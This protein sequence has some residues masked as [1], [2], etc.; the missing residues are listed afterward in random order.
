MTNLLQHQ[1][2]N[3]FQRDKQVL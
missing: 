3:R 1:L 2:S